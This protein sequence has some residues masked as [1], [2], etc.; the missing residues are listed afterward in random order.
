MFEDRLFTV[1]FNSSASVDEGPDNYLITVEGKILCLD[2]SDEERVAGKLRIFFA[3]LD[4]AADAGHDPLYIL[5]MQAG[6]APFYATLFDPET[7]DF[8]KGV[9]RLAGGDIFSRDLLILD[10]LEILPAY[11]GNRLGLACLYRCIQQYWH[12]C[13]L[14]ALKC[15]PLQFEVHTDRPN[16]DGWRQKMEMEGLGT[17]LRSC[18][19]KLEKYYGLLGFKKVGRTEFMILNPSHARPRLGEMGFQ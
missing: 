16:T 18:Q 19:L 15:F 17:E 10:R 1:S 11:R 12:G 13:G 14:V 8:K 2:D 9:Y 3:D 7:N 5:D 4:G 6:T